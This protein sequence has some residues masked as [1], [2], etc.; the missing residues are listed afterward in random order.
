MKL[1]I[2]TAI[3]KYRRARNMTQEELAIALGV[4]PQS[5]SNWEHGGYPDIELL[6]SIAN[7][8][9][10]TVD[11]LIGNDKISFEEDMRRYYQGLREYDGLKN[12]DHCLAYHRKYPNEFP[13]IND[14]CI[15]I[16]NTRSYKKPEYMELL[17]RLSQRV[18]DECTDCLIRD[19]TVWNMCEAAEGEEFEKWVSMLPKYYGSH[20]YE[21]QE[22]YARRT[23]NTEKSKNLN[24]RNNLSIMFHLMERR[25]LTP[26]LCD[27]A[28][29]EE[30]YRFCMKQIEFFGDGTIPDGWLSWHTYFRL[31]LAES[32]FLLGRDDEGWDEL[33]GAVDEAVR[34]IHLPDNVPLD[35]G[36]P[37]LF[38]GIRCVRRMNEGSFDHYICADGTD[39]DTQ[40]EGFCY[41]QNKDGYIDNL[42]KSP[43]FDSVREDARFTC[44][45]EK[46]RQA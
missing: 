31:D 34:V 44:L 4:S 35:M 19:I 14:L 29:A 37:A 16:M 38:R 39:M 22:K 9:G 41:H 28:E 15:M 26:H 21:M 24:G 36:C 40:T 10:I 12:L 20:Y 18:I 33:T 45:V 1:N 46:L 17:R 13:I 23:G 43:G 5:V 2:D 27:P 42:I 3:L 6:P 8:F 32:L 7:Y 25:L 11:E 30:W